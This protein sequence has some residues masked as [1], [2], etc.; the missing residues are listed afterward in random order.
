MSFSPEHPRI[1][2]LEYAVQF[3]ARLLSAQDAAAYSAALRGTA[4]Q[5]IEQSTR[6]SPDR[7]LLAVEIAGALNE[8]AD[9][10]QS[11]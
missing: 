4:D 5:F 1:V 7:G 9:N 2:A 8:I 3:L 6:G 10:A 11:N